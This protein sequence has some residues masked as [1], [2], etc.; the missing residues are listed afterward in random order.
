M[1]MGKPIH[2][3]H[4]TLGGCFCFYFYFYPFGFFIP[5]C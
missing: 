2:E 4:V 1:G 5:L 3:V